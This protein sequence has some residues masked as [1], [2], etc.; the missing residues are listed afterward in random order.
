MQNPCISLPKIHACFNWTVDCEHAFQELKKHLTTPPILV[1]PRDE[2]Q[3]VVNCDV[4]DCSVGSVIQQYQD[5][6]LRVIA[7]ASR[8]LTE[9]ER[10]YCI[11]RQELLA[12]VFGLKKHRQ[13]LLGRSIIVQTN[14]AALTY[15]CLLYTSDAADE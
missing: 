2:G 6:A 5:G 4:S 14:H 8:A 10:R 3:Y 1:A 11:T 15:L 7:Y 9:T 12:V 13:H